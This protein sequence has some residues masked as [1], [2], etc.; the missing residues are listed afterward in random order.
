MRGRKAKR[1]AK[2]V[3]QRERH[4]FEEGALK[5]LQSTGE[6]TP[7]D[8]AKL[9]N[10]TASIHVEHLA[11]K[12][13]K[14]RHKWWH[15]PA[16]RIDLKQSI[17]SLIQLIKAVEDCTRIIEV[18]VETTGRIVRRIDNAEEVHEHAVA[19]ERDFM[20][21]KADLMPNV[22]ATCTGEPSGC[23]AL[24]EEVTY[25]ADFYPTATGTARDKIVRCA[26][27]M[28]IN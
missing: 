6:F 9:R 7:E 25:G 28:R 26:H 18:R 17:D 27:K 21:V 23:G 12:E 5:H 14:K 2:A 19:I 8:I 1:Q 11:V 20:Q 10:K 3:R 4:T 13:M 22:C 15:G 16:S 24:A